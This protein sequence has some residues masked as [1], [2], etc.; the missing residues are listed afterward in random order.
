MHRFLSGVAAVVLG[1][2]IAA[3]VAAAPGAGGTKAPSYYLSLGAGYQAIAQAFL[4]R[5]RP[6]GAARLLAVWRP[7]TGGAVLHGAPPSPEGAIKVRS[8]QGSIRP[9]GLAD[10]SHLVFGRR[11][12]AP[13]PILPPLPGPPGPGGAGVRGAQ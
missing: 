9:P 6:V 3:P 10:P 7:S 13:P 5:A 1:L 11:A 8:R 12:V 2:A 4:G